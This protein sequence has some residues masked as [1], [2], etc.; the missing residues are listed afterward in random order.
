MIRGIAKIEFTLSW[1]LT[2]HMYLALR[3]FE[4]IIQCPSGEVLFTRIGPGSRWTRVVNNQLD[5]IAEFHHSNHITRAAI[6]QNYVHVWNDQ[7]HT[8][9][10]K[11]LN[12]HP[13]S[14]E[15][16]QLVVTGGLSTTILYSIPKHLRDLFTLSHQT[17]SEYKSKM[18]T[19][20][21]ALYRVSLPR[22]MVREIIV[23]CCELFRV[24]DFERYSIELRL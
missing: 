24:H 16:R 11:S 4:S 5:L 14:T 1:L 2:D 3:Y 8:Q 19:C 23:M 12:S 17:L 6:T 9:V 7:C 21:R 13:R 18:T 10:T 22:D 20:I 15:D